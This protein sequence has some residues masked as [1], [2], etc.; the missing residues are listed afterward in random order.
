LKAPTTRQVEE[1]S[2]M[3][4][5]M[6]VLREAIRM[7]RFEQCKAYAPTAG[8]LCVIGQLVLRGTHI[9]LLNKLR[10]QAVAIAQES[11]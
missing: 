4:V 1:A 7:G 8:E 6:T 9:V 3:D 2:A 5:E 11:H 10:P